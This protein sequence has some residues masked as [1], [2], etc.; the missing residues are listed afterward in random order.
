MVYQKEE[1]WGFGREREDRGVS[2]GGVA[3]AVEQTARKR[4]FVQQGFELNF[5]SSIY[6]TSHFAAPV[7]RLL[8]TFDTKKHHTTTPRGETDGG[9]SL[10]VR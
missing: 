6:E 1:R 2:R 5:N 7:D 3:S 10:F 4:S 9:G 8:S